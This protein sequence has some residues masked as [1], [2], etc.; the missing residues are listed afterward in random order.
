MFRYLLPSLTCS[1]YLSSPSK[2]GVTFFKSSV[3]I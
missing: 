1:I 2:I 3:Y